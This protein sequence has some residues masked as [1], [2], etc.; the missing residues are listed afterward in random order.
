[1]TEP[2]RHRFSS[3]SLVRQGDHRFYS[4]TLPSELLAE[5]C[6]VIAREED[7]VKGFQRELDEKRAREIA[8][9]IDSGLGTIPSA[10]ILSAQPDAELEYDRLRK[11]LSFKAIRKAFLIIDGQHRV[12]GFMLAKKAFR[13]PV[14]IYAGL[15]RRDETRLFIDIN[16]KQKGVPAELLL[17]I[18]KLAEYEKDEEELLREIFDTF[19]Q[20]PSSALYGRLSPSSKAPGKISRSVFNTALK[21]LVRVFGEKGQSELYEILNAYFVAL[22]EGVLKRHQQV[23]L[24]FNAIFFRAACAFF[25]I[26][27]PKVKDRFG[28]IYTVDN[29]HYFLEQ[30]GGSIKASKLKGTGSAYKPIVDSLEDALKG[31]FQL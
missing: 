11:S 12:F 15:S 26:V 27:A 1:M 2:E 4:L 23:D 22:I 29:F 7:P 5:T 20:E 31:T 30:V 21:P 19:M 25:L 6:F 28:A 8:A 16:S 9:Y 14:I 13:V 24:L 10:I 18:K 17:D 3:V